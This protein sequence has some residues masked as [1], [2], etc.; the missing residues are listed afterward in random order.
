[1][2]KLLIILQTKDF[3]VVYKPFSMLSVPS[4]FAGADPRPV[5]GLALQTMLNQQIWPCHRLDEDVSGILLFALTDQAHKAANG[6]FE[7]RNV[8][9]TYHALTAQ[10]ENILTEGTIFEWHTK[11]AKGKKRAYEADFGKPS[12]TTATY[13]KTDTSKA[14]ERW[15]LTPHTGRSHQLR[16]DMFKHG[17]PILGDSL[18]GSK[19]TFDRGGIALRSTELDFT[20]CDVKNLQIP[21]RITLPNEL[22]LWDI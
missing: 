14:A 21:I 4:R 3:C 1:M 6:W 11:L 8:I 20:K 17:R 13:L 10:S 22:L 16:F 15:V 19:Q 9:K 18:Y 12:H 2:E 7:S 5:A